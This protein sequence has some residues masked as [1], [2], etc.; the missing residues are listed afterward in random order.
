MHDKGLVQ[1]RRYRSRV[2][3]LA[4]LTMVAVVVSIVLWQN[5]RT[6]SA[7]LVESAGTIT[8]INY[9]RSGSVVNAAEVSVKFESPGETHSVTFLEVTA[10][11]DFAVGDKLEISFPPESPTQAI[12]TYQMASNSPLTS[13]HLLFTILVGLVA[14][15]AVVMSCFRQFQAARRT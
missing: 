12:P 14:V 8:E 1:E 2:P 5:D 6:S 3:L 13:G 9:V 10:D 7:N 15:I 11:R 4:I